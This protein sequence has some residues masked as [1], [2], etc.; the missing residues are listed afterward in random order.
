MH[1][2][3]GLNQRKYQRD[4]GTARLD[5]VYQGLLRRAMP[6]IRFDEATYLAT[7][8]NEY[9]QAVAQFA[10]A[11]GLD[12]RR[13]FVFSA[14]GM[15]G[16]FHAIRKAR[17]FMLAEL[18]K[19]RRAVDNVHAILSLAQAGKPLAAVHI[20]RGDFENVKHGTDFRGR[21]NAALPLEWYLATCA[22][23]KQG[24]RGQL[25]FLLLTDA[26]ADEVRPFID[27]FRPLTT[28]HL[29][30]T[31]CSDLLLMA[32]A[33][34]IV[35]SVSSYS[36]WG[37]FL[38]NAPYIWYSPNLQDHGGFGSL[39]GHEPAQQGPAGTTAQNLERIRQAGDPGP[40][41][42]LAVD[43][44]GEVPAA[45]CEHLLAGASARALEKDLIFYGVVPLPRVPVT[46]DAS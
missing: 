34:C 9:Q 28:F 29:R 4:F 32:F 43:A 8:K 18:L 20:R 30:Q 13:H 42:G 5:W 6:T 25:Q 1:P 35:C 33:D 17:V 31:A 46:P 41:R 10:A 39:W 24:C 7:G 12:R 2:A 14:S 36:M 22:A 15:W 26:S 23:L 45:F 16:G 19:A 37:A 3:W 21:F 44:S 27:A 40:G 38:S 11:Q